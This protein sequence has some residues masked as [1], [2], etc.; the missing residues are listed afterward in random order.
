MKNFKFNSVFKL[1]L[2]V[3]VAIILPTC[4]FA[5]GVP[6]TLKIKH[7]DYKTPISFPQTFH[8]KETTDNKYV[9]CMT[10]AKKVPVT[11]V[12]YTKSTKYTDAGVNY[13]LEQGY[14]AKNDKEY[15]VAQTALWIYLMD[16]GDMNYSNSVNT[17]KSNISKSSGTYATKIKNMVKTAKSKKSYDQSNPTISLSSGNV[18]FTLSSDKKYYVS[19]EIVVKSSEANYKV[20][21]VNAPSG[22]TYTNNNG[23]IVVSVPVGSVSKNVSNFS[24]KVSVSKTIYTAYKYKPSDSKYQVMGAIFPVTKSVSDSKKMSLA[25]DEI[26]ISKQDVTTKSELP[27]A[28]LVV[29]DSNGNVVDTWVSTTTPHKM[30]N[31]TVGKYTLTETIAPE[32]YDLSSEVISFEVT[33]KGVSTP[34]IMYNSPTKVRN[35]YISKQDITTKSELPGATLVLKDSNGKV[36]DTWVSTTTPHVIPATD[37]PSGTYTLTETIAP[38]GYDLSSEVISFEIKDEGEI[39]PVVMYNTP[40]KEVI[41]KVSV[42]K[43]D[44][45]SKDFVP[46]A[47]LQILDSKGEVVKTIISSDSATVIEGLEAGTYT[48]IEVEAPD[49]YELSSEKVE[50]KV[51]EN[52][53]DVVYVSF[54]NKRIP[55]E[56]VPKEEVI[57]PDTGSY[58]TMTSSMIGL[59]ILVVGSVLITKNIRK[60]NEI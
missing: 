30:S 25:V 23:K 34:V 40:S 46:G 15:F 51:I 20:E 21:L 60:K 52:S 17:F 9:F 5:S 44:G 37:L 14:N 22:T 29:K 1:I 6:S 11:S 12:K 28:T 48:L 4:V 7:R 24:L 8:V 13:I 3:L 49:G 32:G 18:S 31:L 36:I 53:E 16:K 42:S 55:S 54:V 39:T 47:T 56:E 35:I 27:G 45:D 59:F 26:T 10:Y 33:N 41:S 19:N 38:E 57:V 2:V 50:F 58:K 43:I